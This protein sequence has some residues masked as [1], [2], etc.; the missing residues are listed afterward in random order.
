M[1]RF[2]VFATLF[3]ILIVVR[4]PARADT[5]INFASSGGNGIT[6]THTTGGEY[7]TFSNLYVGSGYIGDGSSPLT[8]DSSMNAPVVIS[9]GA[10]GH[11]FLNSV[12]SDGL[13]GY[14]ASN[15]AATLTIGNASSGIMKGSLSMIEIDTNTSPT[16]PNGHGSFAL[17]LVLSNLSFS[18]C[19]TTGCTNS[20]LLQNFA[21]LGNGSNASNTLTFSFSSSTATNAASLLGLTGSHGTTVEGTLDSSLDSVAPEPA[22]LALFGSC[23]LMAGTKIYRRAVKA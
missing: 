2:L 16:H 6:F 1:K 3:M 7:I 15:A 10:G 5:V 20:T 19:S 4:I 13:T 14:F 11:F 12:S 9:P 21:Q 17:T 8:G 18:S 22:S 23:L